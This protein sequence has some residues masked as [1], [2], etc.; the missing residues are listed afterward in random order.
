MY[1]MHK[2]QIILAYYMV[3]MYTYAKQDKKAR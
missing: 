2:K 3:E 1:N